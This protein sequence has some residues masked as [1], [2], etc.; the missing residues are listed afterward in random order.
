MKSRLVVA[1]IFLATL[2]IALYF[3]AF[4]A[5][6][7]R[8]PSSELPPAPPPP[9]R[10]PNLV[11][12]REAEPT[13]EPEPQVPRQAG[14]VRV[15]MVGD[16]VRS[17]TAWLSQLWTYVPEVH[18]QAWY[19]TAPE[20][21]VLHAPSAPPLGGMPTASDLDGTQVLVVAGLD[22][23][24]LPPEF[25]TR[26]GELVR[27]GRLGLLLVPD[28]VR[29]Q[30]MGS[31][32]AFRSILPFARVRG[33]EPATPGGPPAGVFYEARPFVLTEEG[34]T[35]PTAQIVERWPNWNR[36][37]WASLTEGGSKAPFASKLCPI[38]EG[39]EP[40][41]VVVATLGSGGTSPPAIVASGGDARVLWLGGLME[42][43]PSA[44]TTSRSVLAMRALMHQWV[45]WLA[46]GA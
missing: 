26:A 15:L 24:A 5:T 30:S 28:D 29:A 38:V 25:W 45:R 33:L 42:I 27:A 21:V 35:H 7:K 32:E 43:A 12:T 22:P 46:R 11:P 20:G 4:G 10:D 1:A 17:F 41:A 6:P 14:P 8:P 31:I 2:G 37:W 18:W 23:T 44:Y 3:F 9:I 16:R 34:A 19:V 36:R 13:E 40:D 39:V